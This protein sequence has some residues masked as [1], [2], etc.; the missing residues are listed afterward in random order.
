M[1]SFD[2]ELFNDASN[3]IISAQEQL[4]NLKNI[5]DSISN[6]TVECDFKDNIESVINSIQLIQKSIIELNGRMKRTTLLADTSK[7]LFVIF[8][9]LLGKLYPHDS[10]TDVLQWMIE[11]DTSAFSFTPG[12]YGGAQQNPLD[13]YE[14]YIINP[15]QL[16][17][18]E[19]TKVEKWIRSLGY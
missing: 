3:K 7:E 19:K 8:K 12:Q 10:W 2:E 6:I 11:K 5:I 13:L 1:F 18:V 15:E 17:D 16:N 9:S 4:E 14:K